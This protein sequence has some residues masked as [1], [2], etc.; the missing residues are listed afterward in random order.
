MDQISCQA[1]N[2]QG[3]CASVLEYQQIYYEYVALL[4]AVG[5]ARLNGCPVR[6][7]GTLNQS[8]LRWQMS[9]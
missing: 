2:Y 6:D 7:V 5:Y 1:V 9:L 8:G 3:I 4:L